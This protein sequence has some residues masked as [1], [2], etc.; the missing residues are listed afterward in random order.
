MEGGILHWPLQ[1][2]SNDGEG[3]GLLMGGP[4]GASVVACDVGGKVGPG[5]GIS[6]S[7]LYRMEKKM[8]GWS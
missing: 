4:T 6:D 5:E 3:S 8:D 1:E 7:P 2:G